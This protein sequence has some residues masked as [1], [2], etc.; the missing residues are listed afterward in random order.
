MARRSRRI[1]PGGQDAGAGGR[2]APAAADTPPPGRPGTVAEVVVSYVKFGAVLLG[3]FTLS[4]TSLAT[5]LV[6]HPVAKGIAKLA[7]LLLRLFNI[8]AQAQG[9]VIHSGSFAAMVDTNC[10]GLFVIFIYLSALVAYP[11]GMR[12]KAFGVALGCAALFTLNL[13]RVATLVIVGSARP[14]M[15]NVA[16]YLI[17]Q[18]LMIVAAICLWLFWAER[19]ADA[20]GH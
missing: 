14:D 10:T 9:S 5:T 15:L 16:H 20:P 7:S 17:W 11:S 1:R 8:D 19:V 3:L 18:S 2:P 4:Q 12:E 13:L 6:F